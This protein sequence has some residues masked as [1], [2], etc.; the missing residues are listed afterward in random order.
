[1]KIHPKKTTRL[2]KG[3]QLTPSLGRRFQP[4]KISGTCISQYIMLMF[5]NP[6]TMAQ[7]ISPLKKP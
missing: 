1:M 4:S 2:Y 5:V 6:Y 7:S 3:V